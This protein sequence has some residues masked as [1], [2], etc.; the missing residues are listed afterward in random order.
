MTA[1]DKMNA[2]VLP[3][4]TG[5]ALQLASF[6]DAHQGEAILVCGCGES[7]N[8]LDLPV[9]VVTIG[10]NDVGRRFHPDYLVVVN[11]PNQFTHDR[12]RH[13]ESSRA[14]YV[15]TQLDLPITHPRIVRFALGK[16][17]GTDLS[18]PNV[19]HFTQNSPYVALCLAVHLGARRIGLIGVDFTENHFFAR[20]G[21]HP[22]ASRLDQID[23]EFGNLA[24]ACRALGVEI[25]NLSAKSRLSALPRASL[26]GFLSQARLEPLSDVPANAPDQRRLFVVNYRFL[27]CGSLL[28]DGLRHAASEL[29]L[30]Y[31]DAYWD[32]AQLL[33]RISRFAPD[34][35][36]VVHGRRFAQRWG[37][38][39]RSYNT[40]V[41]L[42]DE[43]Y[44]VDDTASWSSRFDTVFVND[45][46]T[47]ARHRNAYYLPMGF[48]DR[49]HRDT[50]RERKYRVGFIG[51]ANATRERYLLRLAEAGLLD[52][53]VGGPWQDPVLLKLCLAA[54][55]PAE[56]TAELYQQTEIVLN[57]FREVH[58]F[59]RQRVA[60]YAMNPRIYEALA[61]GALVVSEHR[62]EIEDVFVELPQFDSPE[63]LIA[64]VSGF[65]ADRA[66]LART[67]AAC[68]A[69]LAGHSYKERV[70]RIL[71][72]TVGGPAHSAPPLDHAGTDSV[73]PQVCAPIIEGWE[74]YGDVEHR[75]DGC[76]TVLE[77]L[78]NESS[79][80]ESGLVSRDA[81]TDVEL[82]FDLRLGADAWF[83]AKI[84]QLD[85]YDQSSNSYHI[86]LSSR[87]D[88]VARHFHIFSRLQVPR[89]TWQHVVLRCTD[90]HW[91]E[92]VIEGVVQARH[93]ENHL[94]SGY[95]FLGIKGG[96]VELKNVQLL[97]LSA[98]CEGY[99]AQKPATIIA[100]PK[101]AAAIP[102]RDTSRPDRT[103]PRRNLI[104]H[105]WPVR[106]STWRWN[107]DQL[108]KRIDLF[109]GSRTVAIVHDTRSE[110]PEAVQDYLSGH[111][112]EFI[113]MPNDARGEA[114]TFPSLLAK[115]TQRPPEEVTFY[116]HTKGVKYEPEFPECVRKWT[117][118]QYRVALDD[119]LTVKQ[120]MQR[121]PMTGPFRIPGR[122]RAHHYVSD[123][124][125]SGNFFWMRNAAIFS[126]RYR[127]VPQFYGGVE[128]WPGVMFSQNE[129]GCLLMD[130][131]RQLPYY[132]DFWRED[133]DAVVQ[134]W[135]SKLCRA[136]APADLVEPAPF[137]GYRS[138]RLEQKPEEFAWW[139]EHL[140]SHNVER[141]LTIG[142]MCGGA[143]WHTARVFSE[144]N[145]K[146]DITAVDI[147]ERKELQDAFLDIRNRFGQSV[148]LIVGD[149]ASEHV[150]A[151]LAGPYDAAFIDGDH[152]YAGARKDFLLARSLGAR[153]IGLH[154]IV[155]SDWHAD[156]RCCVSRLWEEVSSQHQAEQCASGE[157]GG[158]G[159][160]TV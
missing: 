86:V 98:Q 155:D 117:E 123:W 115:L 62:A 128:A 145:R 28:A 38:R 83:L 106:G 1:A 118:V 15:V 143:E 39:F 41:W 42:T 110:G 33:E 134:A 95:C 76:L 121:F 84:R 70:M 34:L 144:Q 9:G 11:P 127:D 142:S 67:K 105:V 25:V 131:I 151:E 154:D 54:D 90:Q 5:T 59:N 21:A 8:E 57:V 138:P 158:I 93:C 149:S 66:Q 24:Q 85:Q 23:R 139:L 78:L 126:D 19:L 80:S 64:V 20:T 136:S 68:R 82:S 65:L 137:A 27:S 37:D 74:K 52:Y 148:K 133:G 56:R 107:L 30:C 113:I 6:K 22:L 72:L 101:P 94:L 16:P 108:K 31:A 150:R 17:A 109:N 159:V 96:G 26:A 135:E 99:A 129:T 100:Q 124:H 116:G 114:V 14:H 4:A 50:G 77:K 120:H 44:E 71:E 49:I 29:G 92:V 47:V 32:D 53:V 156:A 125:Y 79:G 132:E 81:Y 97:D 3:K 51:G 2:R 102:D 112:C 75:V 141:L 111:G 104:Y 58:H 157:W 122:F 63:K 69:R 18:N 153:L 48:D 87:H 61:C 43:P 46:N 10:V 40:A 60:P 146:I 89:C 13:V 103:P 12:F 140:L 130:N 73:K 35:L 91:L 45:P 160:I 119:W 36:L 147:L 7:L 88:Y 152:S 55:V